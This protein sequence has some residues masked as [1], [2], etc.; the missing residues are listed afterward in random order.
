MRVRS[1]SRSSIELVSPLGPEFELIWRNRKICHVSLAFSQGTGCLFVQWQ[2][3]LS[4]C[5]IA[6]AAKLRPPNELRSG[7]CGDDPFD[8]FNAVVAIAMLPC[9]VDQFGQRRIGGLEIPKNS[10]RR[11]P[12][13]PEIVFD[14]GSTFKPGASTL[15]MVSS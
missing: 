6:K 15:S 4:A 10:V 8:Q 5:G 9:C 1:P 12:C 3:P 11:W 14:L 2:C 7:F 13:R